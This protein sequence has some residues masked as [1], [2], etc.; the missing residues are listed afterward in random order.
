M[1]RE[2]FLSSV[3]MIIRE[4]G[5]ILLQRR[6]GTKIYCGFLALPAGHMDKGENSYEAMIRESRE[7]LGITVTKED[8]SDIFVVQRRSAIHGPYYDVYF[9][10]KHY[11]GEIKIMEPNKCSEIVWADEKD[12][13]LDMIKFE[14]DALEMNAKGVKFDCVDVLREE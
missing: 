13:P 6:T 12:L 11:E 4:D 5:K 8:I 2:K 10:L 9:E 14:R 3:Y 7:E 1:E